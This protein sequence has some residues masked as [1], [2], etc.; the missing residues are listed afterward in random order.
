VSAERAG[1][2]LVEAHP[3]TGRRSLLIGRHAYGIAGLEPDES[4]RS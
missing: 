3:E 1:R 4:E 2:P